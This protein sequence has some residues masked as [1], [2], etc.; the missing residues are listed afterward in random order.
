MRK[1]RRQWA[2]HPTTHRLPLLPYVLVGQHAPR[3]RSELFM[4]VQHL[5]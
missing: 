1:R 2:V 3:D 4:S 5:M